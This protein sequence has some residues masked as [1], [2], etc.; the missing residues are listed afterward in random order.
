MI[1]LLLLLQATPIAPANT[2]RPAHDAVG[3]NVRITIPD[4]GKEIRADT[5]TLWRLL[6]A[7]PIRVELDTALHVDKVT[8]DD[9]TITNWRRDGELILIPHR[10]AIG[11]HVQTVISYHG[12]PW[13]G[14][15]I[16]DSAGVRTIFADNWPNRA[17]R[18]FPSQD[19]PSD[20]ATAE[21]HVN[22]ASEYQVIANGELA[23]RGSADAGHSTWFFQTRKPIPVYTMVIGV[24]KMARTSM[25][26]GGCAVRC[27]P[28]EVLT[29]PA[30]SAYAVTGPFRRVKEILDYFTGVIGEFPYSRLT[31][32]QSST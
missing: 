26:E 4:S 27:V 19:Y 1:A 2:P 5:Y 15:V 30:D 17:H 23:G 18:W 12:T 7:D 22:V 14:L 8:L 9:R 20:K 11:D 29:Y 21:F 32:V 13:D 6:S 28:L 16:R 25:G 10:H 3:Y 24:A 31:H